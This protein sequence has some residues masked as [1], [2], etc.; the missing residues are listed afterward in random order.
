MTV[1]LFNRLYYVIPGAKYTHCMYHFLEPDA[2]LS[3]LLLKR[4]LSPSVFGCEPQG[5]LHVRSDNTI[6]FVSSIC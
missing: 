2:N 1:I 4:E 3:G 6:G 5:A